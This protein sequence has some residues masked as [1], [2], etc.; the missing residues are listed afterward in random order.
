MRPLP[1]N[2]SDLV[3]ESEASRRDEKNVFGDILD[4]IDAGEWFDGVVDQPSRKKKNLLQGS[5]PAA[6]GLKESTSDPDD[7]PIGAIIAKVE[8]KLVTT[9]AP[10]EVATQSAKKRPYGAMEDEKWE[11]VEPLKRKSK[12]KGKDAGT[13]KSPEVI[14]AA[15]VIKQ[16]LAQVIEKKKKVKEG[17]HCLKEN[18]LLLLSVNKLDKELREEEIEQGG[19]EA[20]MKPLLKE[21]SEEEKLFGD[22]CS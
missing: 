5:I 12:K 14:L 11:L 22:N 16:L 7:R 17:I 1:P 15:F 18:A 9:K 19:L 10:K 13:Y 20:R 2:F 8:K 6:R 4:T 3:G 21:Q